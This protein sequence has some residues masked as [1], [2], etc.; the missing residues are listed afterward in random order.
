MKRD[1]P[2]QGRRP[3]KERQ[4][5][6]WLDRL[7]RLESHFGRFAR[8]V[9]GVFLLALALI[10]LLAL[11]GLTRGALLIL[12]TAFLRRWFGWGSY[13]LVLGIGGLGVMVLR[14]SDEPPRWGRLIALELAGFFSL[15]VLTL[16]GGGSLERAEKGLDGG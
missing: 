2:P 9:V 15:A 13:L 8:D 6:D 5:E 14:R 7:V 12:W 4:P 3:A 16:L 11:P 10:S 1:S